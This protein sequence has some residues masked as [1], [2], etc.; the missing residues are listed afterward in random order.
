[1]W[2]RNKYAQFISNRGAGQGG[3]VRNPHTDLDPAGKTQGT[4]NG[5][6]SKG[7]PH[8]NTIIQ[9]QGFGKTI[10]IE[11]TVI[12]VDVFGH[13]VKRLPVKAEKTVWDCREVKN[14]IYFYR[15]EIDGKVVVQK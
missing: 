15:M 10:F 8:S 11:T 13:E 14:G 12:I 1:M 7:I 5:S 2:C 6:N 9:T 4:G 3:G